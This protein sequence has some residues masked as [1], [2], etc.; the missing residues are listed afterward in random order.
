MSFVFI[1]DAPKLM[2]LFSDIFTEEFMG[3][4][5][6]FQSFEG[7]RYS[8]AVIVNWDAPRMVYN[9]GLLDRFVQ[10]STDFPSWDAMV[11]AAT[12]ARYHSEQKG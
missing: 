9:D 7:F 6:R 4:H 1:D 2:G 5:T 8:S 3:H 11:R 12:E 10:E